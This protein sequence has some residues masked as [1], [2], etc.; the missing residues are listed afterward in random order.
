MKKSIFK[1]I[2]FKITLF[3]ILAA[4]VN[5]FANR[6]Y[7]TSRRLFV[8]ERSKNAN[9][10]CYDVNLNKDGK[11]NPLKPLYAYWIMRAGNGSKRNLNMFEKKAYGFI[12]K[13]IPGTDNY[14]LTLAAFNKKQIKILQKNSQITPII[15]INGRQAV[16]KKIYVKSV[17]KDILPQVLYVE[18][19]GKDLQTKASVYEKINN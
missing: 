1:P 5:C 12:I 6:A 17:E 16:L 19:F 9:I 11:I 10:V 2:I 18:V 8:I 7:E 15:E 3:I 4:V 13:N 14:T